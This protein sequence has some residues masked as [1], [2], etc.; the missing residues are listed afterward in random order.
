MLSH[1]TRLRC[2][3]VDLYYSLYGTKR[4]VCIPVAQLSGIMTSNKQDI[5]KIKKI[6]TIP[7]ML[8]TTSAE[9]KKIISPASTSKDGAPQVIMEAVECMN[10]EVVASEEKIEKE[11]EIMEVKAESP[12][13]QKQEYFSDNSVSLPGMGQSGPVGFEPGMFQKDGEARHK[14]DS[15]GRVKKKKKD[16]K[17]HKHKHKHKHEHKHNK[18]KER[19]DKDPNRITKLKEETLS[20][21]S[22]TPSPNPLSLGGAETI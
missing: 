1:D 2:D 6:P 18:D 15:P 8:T 22:S 16:K 7:K 19:K 9:A 3:L 14:S 13:L 12:I 21:T 5:T 11:A 20:S 4:P 10:V 17:K